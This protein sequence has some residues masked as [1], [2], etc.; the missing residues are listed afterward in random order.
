M[1]DI[2]DYCAAA[3]DP[4]VKLMAA[5]FDIQSDPGKGAEIV[6]IVDELL[7]NESARPAQMPAAA[8]GWTRHGVQTL[9]EIRA[10]AEAGDGARVWAAFSDR[11]RGMYLLGQACQGHAGW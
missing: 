8:D 3:K 4:T 6:T 11:E 7:A 1:A 9:R 2:D 10:A 5:A